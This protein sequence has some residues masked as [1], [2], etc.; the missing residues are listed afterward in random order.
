MP[1]ISPRRLVADAEDQPSAAF[2]A[3]TDGILADRLAR[4]KSLL[5]LQI[6]ALGRLHQLLQ[7]ILI[8]RVVSAAMLHRSLEAIA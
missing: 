3:D 7:A 4:Q 8:H 6:L 5:E 2:V 1:T